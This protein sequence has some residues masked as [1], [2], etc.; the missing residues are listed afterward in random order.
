MKQKRVNAQAKVTVNL[1]SALPTFLQKLNSCVQLTLEMSVNADAFHFYW[2]I[3]T[4]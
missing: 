4:C 3:Y 1:P 2:H